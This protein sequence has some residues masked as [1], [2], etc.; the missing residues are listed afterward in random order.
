MTKVPKAAARKRAACAPLTPET[1]ARIRQ[2]YADGVP[3]GRIYAENKVTKTTLYTWLDGGPPGP[4]RLP[5][6][7]RREHAGRAQA[8]PAMLDGR[9]VAR[10]WRSASRQIDEIGRR[11]ARAGLSGEVSQGDARTLAVLVKTLREL[12][13]LNE[14]CVRGAKPSASSRA[15]PEDDTIPYDLDE[16]RRELA[17]RIEILRRGRAADPGTRDAEG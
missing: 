17:R 3:I 13:A 15:E 11:L 7:P 4:G 10:L 1:I 6:I 14:T 16:L 8:A 5:P 2:Q 9:L 12:V